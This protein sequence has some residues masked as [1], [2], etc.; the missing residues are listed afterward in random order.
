VL[1]ATWGWREEP[2]LKYTILGHQ[3]F[4]AGDRLTRKKG[5]RCN[6]SMTSIKYQDNVGDQCSKEDRDRTLAVHFFTFY[7]SMKVEEDKHK[8]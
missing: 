3:D 6:H 5:I 7:L 2:K 1:G 8:K 4:A